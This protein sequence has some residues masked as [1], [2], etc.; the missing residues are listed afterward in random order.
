MVAIRKSAGF[1]HILLLILLL[2]IVAAVTLTAVK[3]IQN[4]KAVQNEREL[5]AKLDSEAQA[6]IQ[7]I[8]AKYPGKVTHKASCNYSSAKLGRGALGCSV[9]TSIDYASVDDP[10]KILSFADAAQKQ[11]PWGVGIDNTSNIV[12]S[13]KKTILYLHGK[14]QSCAISYYTTQGLGE[15]LIDANCD[16]PALAEYYPVIGN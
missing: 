5:Y 8:N 15:L 4:K 6:Y 1:A 3:V 2:V 7:A 12:G 14:K 11:L 16:G 13:P 9:E 10:D